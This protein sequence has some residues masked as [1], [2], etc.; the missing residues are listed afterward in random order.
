MALRIRAA[1]TALLV[2]FTPLAASAQSPIPSASAA[3]AVAQHTLPNGLRVVAIEDH[4]AAVVQTAV[5]YRFG[6][7]DERRGKTGLAHAL[8][9][10]MFR[11]TKAVSGG[12]LDDIGARLGAIVNANT[13]E[14]YTHYYFVM[15]A[16]RL[17]LAMHIEA[18]RMRGLLLRQSDWVLEKGA[19]LAEI[20]GDYSQPIFKLTQGVRQSAYAGTP[21]AF[22]ALGLRSDVVRSTSA[23]LRTYY[24]A[25][26]APNNATLV[27]TGDVKPD[28]VFRYADEYFGPIPARALP[29]RTPQPVPGAAA[30][31]TLNVSADY[32]YSV[33]D[34]A[35]RIPGDL[36]TDAGA[37]QVFANLINSE[38]SAFY[39]NLVLSKLALGYQAYPDTALHA[40]IFHVLIFVTPGRKPEAARRAFEQ[41]LNTTLSTGI[42][43]DLLAAAKTA[44]ARQA[45]YSR[46]SIAGLGDRYGYAYGVEGHDPSEDDRRVEALDDA[47]MNAA[48]KRYF[49]APAVVGVLTPR[50]Q[51]AASGGNA[52]PG[53]SVTDDFS[54]RVPNGPIVLAPWAKRALVKPLELASNVTPVTFTLANGLRLFVQEVHTNPTVFVSGSIEVSPLF[55]PARKTGLGAI[56]SGLLGYGSKEYDFNA[57]RKLADELGADINFG[58]QFGAHGLARDLDRL[59]SVLA[60]GEEHPAFPPRFFELVRAQEISA[61]SQREQSPD[62]RA[63]KAFL[64]A[65]YP[66]RDP[67]LREETVQSLQAVA[68][69]DVRAYARRYIRPDHTTIVVAGDVKAADVRAKIEHAFARWQN[70]GSAPSTILPPLPLTKA[71]VRF[72]PA[73]RDAV[74]V[75]L[76]ESAIGRRNPDF[77]AMNLLNGVLGADGTFD[78]RLMHEIRE[79]RGLVYSVSSALSV[80]RERGT[81]EINFSANPLNVAPAVRLIKQNLQRMIDQPVGADELN[82]ARTKLVAGTLVAEESTQTLVARC[83]AIARYRL[84][85]DYY[86]TF[87]R[88]Y[89]RYTPADLL[90]VA[91]KYIRPQRIVEVYEGPYTITARR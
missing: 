26:Y 57:Q 46:D 19:V 28:D 74:S 51:S 44:N 61:V 27:I 5:W 68:P 21:Y 75:H 50:V 53:G 54:K 89:A 77:Y 8:E 63:E 80:T 76:G 39:K 69:A 48:V 86:R 9:H 64:Q 24:D 17:E 88:R 73:Q 15:P 66:P 2:V 52:T 59:L 85:A 60:D 72:I 7:L 31:P 3:P 38:R 12:G 79:Q 29:E 58:F 25:Y 11:G 42:D 62:V 30:Q 65:V 18:D 49:R 40:G 34:Y 55:D 45:V 84:P 81:F 56:T 67:I 14:D 71:A 36:D 82:R 83:E 91:R 4:A 6:S 41:T 37:T 87:A 35:Y 20:D 47:T 1:L 32:P 78:T 16:D 22:T 90:A 43:S 13:A 70:V 10:M 23:D 33:V